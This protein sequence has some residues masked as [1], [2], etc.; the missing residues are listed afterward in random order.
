M[1][2]IR[3]TECTYVSAMCLS[4]DYFYQASV[5]ISREWHHARFSKHR[6]A[7][8]SS[9][10]IEWEWWSLFQVL[11]PGGHESLPQ[12]TIRWTKSQDA[13]DICTPC[14]YETLHIG[15][16]WADG[17]AKELA[18]VG[19]MCIVM[20]EATYQNRKFLL[21]TNHWDIREADDRTRWTRCLRYLM[22]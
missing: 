17:L 10:Y 15:M 1:K 9:K 18:G 7:L 8:K 6:G 11:I 5:R 13:V 3:G 16:F 19:Y 14:H 21:G 22:Y 12:L 4:I 20:W 2:L